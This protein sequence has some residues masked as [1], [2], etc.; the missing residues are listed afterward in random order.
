MAYAGS[1]SMR[2][3][4]RRGAL[5]TLLVSAAMAAAIACSTFGAG[6]PTEEGGPEAG[7]TD[8]PVPEAAT[9]AGVDADADACVYVA[10]AVGA[11]GT[12]ATCPSG[13]VRTGCSAL[14]RNAKAGGV[15]AIGSDGCSGTCV[16]LSVE[17]DVFAYCA[18]VSGSVRIAEGSGDVVCDGGGVRTGCTAECSDAASHSLPVGAATC[19]GTC[20][21][22]GTPRVQALCAV[23]DDLS[24][25]AVSSGTGRRAALIGCPPGKRPLDCS[26]ECGGIY[27]SGTFHDGGEC[28]GRCDEPDAAVMVSAVCAAV[29]CE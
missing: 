17:V 12:S 29:A 27:G 20:S 4:T 8:A 2:R 24:Q 6:D 19:R 26:S 25:V 5:V 16:S 28:S 7:A 13:T 11:S 18:R 10:H 1:V 9:D 23:S 22:G 15:L 3:A 21:G 14:C